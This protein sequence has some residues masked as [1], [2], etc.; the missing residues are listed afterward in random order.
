MFHNRVI[1]D[2]R[3]IHGSMVSISFSFT[4]PLEEPPLKTPYLDE[5]VLV[6]GREN[7]R[8]MCFTR[9]EPSPTAPN[10]L[11]SANPRKNSA[12]LM[13]LQQKQASGLGQPK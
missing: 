6:C 12:L 4:R 11:W 3:H 9:R 8:S 7:A 13:F 5:V 1:V 2:T 10:S